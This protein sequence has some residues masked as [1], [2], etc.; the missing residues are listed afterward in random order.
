LAP[1]ILI[2]MRYATPNNFTKTKL[3]DKAVCLLCEPTAVRL[4]RVQKNLK[5]EG[6]GLKV[7]DCYRPLSVQQ[8][9]WDVV[10]DARYVANPKTGSRH[11][12]GA[13]V[14]LTLVDSKGNELPMPTGFDDFR[15]K[16]HRDTTDLP[17]KVI[18]NRQKLQD[19]MEAEGFMSLPTE[20]WH[21]D[22][23][24][25]KNYALRNEPLS[26]PRLKKERLTSLAG[27][28]LPSQAKQII[29]VTSKDWKSKTATLRRFD[30]ERG[31]WGKA[32]EPIPVSL[33]KKGMAWGQGLH[34]ALSEGP[35]KREG[36]NRATAGIFKI[37]LSYG[38]APSPP[39]EGS[40]PY[41]KVN[42]QW[43][44]IDDPKSSVYNR[45]FP[46]KKDQPK[47]WKSAEKMKRKDHL[48]KWVIN[49]EQNTPS[50]LKGAGSC[51]FFHVWR[52]KDSPTQGC[53]AMREEDILKILKWLDP[54]K[55]PH[56]VQ[57]PEKVYRKVK[58][59]W[60]IP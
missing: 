40:W 49:I 25:W 50:V 3:Y 20:W 38:Y 55:K 1:G 54:K 37:G 59:K 15:K 53:T 52:R 43:L 14:D 36:D 28:Q 60:K 42:S 13:A 22:D 9:L 29:V 16:A 27:T 26:D 34:T 24:E 8:K 23:P 30:W 47:D 5:K 32:G 4:A 35:Q 45:I 44:C 46:L 21:F 48:Y 11:N 58:S 56:L 12:R 10:P 6:L 7:W 2:E 51:I 18:R 41:Q 57:L 33:G 17:K 39:K 19:A 31:R